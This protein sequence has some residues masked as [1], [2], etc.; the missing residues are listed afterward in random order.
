MLTINVFIKLPKQEIQ[1]FVMKYRCYFYLFTYNSI[2][3]VYWLHFVHK[4][5]KK[6]NAEP[7]WENNILC[8]VIVDSIKSYFIRTLSAISA[9]W[10]HAERSGTNIAT[11]T[12]KLWPYYGPLYQDH[13]LFTAKI[14]TRRVHNF[15]SP[16]RPNRPI[17]C[18]GCHH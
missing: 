7:L 6:V 11:L 13:E 15:L 10:G 1:V 17:T 5:S 18:S 8:R 3:S 9:H 12:F 2:F 14:K 16:T 4:E